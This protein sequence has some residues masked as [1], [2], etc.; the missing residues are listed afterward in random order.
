MS[1]CRSEAG[2]LF[3]ILGTAITKLLRPSRVFVLRTVSTLA[4]A[5]RSRG[6]VRSPQSVDSRRPGTKELDLAV[7][8]RR[9]RQVTARSTIVNWLQTLDAHGYAL[10]MP[11]YS[12]FGEQILGSVIGILWLRVQESGSVYQPHCG[13]LALNLDCDQLVVDPL[14]HRYCPSIEYLFS[15]IWSR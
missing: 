10:L 12:L 13:S 8:C 9:H 1:G 14:F 15:A 6:R 7:T 11:V 2:K 3:Q 4:R 5:E